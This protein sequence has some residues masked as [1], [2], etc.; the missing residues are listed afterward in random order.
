MPANKKLDNST[1]DRK[2]ALRLQAL[3]ELGEVPPVILET[4]AGAGK[5]F[6]RCYSAC[7]EGVAFDIDPL[8]TVMLARQ[9]P[10]WSVYE[11]DSIKALA[12]GA[13]DHLALNFVDCDPYGEPWPTIDAFWQSKRPR[14]P[15]VV[16][17]VNDGLRQMVRIQGGWSVESLHAKVE[18]YGNG[19]HGKYLA[20]A[21]ELMVDKGAAAGY[22]LTRWAGYYCGTFSDM[23]H[24]AA[25]FEKAA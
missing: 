21:R 16:M 9:R 10:T 7:R 23:T 25:V 17:V 5:I 22:K 1:Y 6:A 8:K 24:Y 14:A 20:I 11:A 15:K 13:G 2:V 4:H 18:K 19:L 3:R 12:N